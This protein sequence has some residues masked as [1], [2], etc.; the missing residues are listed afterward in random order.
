MQLVYT[1]HSAVEEDVTMVVKING[2]DTAVKAPGMVVELVADNGSLTPRFVP[3]D[4]EAAR[5]LFAVGEKIKV[6]FS[7]A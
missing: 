2:A 6:N 7:A 3:A 4:M 5:K 1:V